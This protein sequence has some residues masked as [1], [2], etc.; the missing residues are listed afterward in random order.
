MEVE[1][2]MMESLFVNVFSSIVC[3]VILQGQKDKHVNEIFQLPC[4]K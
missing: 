4:K 2:T 3:D 1:K